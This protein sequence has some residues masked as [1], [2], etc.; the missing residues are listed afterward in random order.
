MPMERM[1]VPVPEAI[2]AIGLGR[3]K[4]YQLIRA[5]DLTLVHVGRRSFVPAESLHAFVER[6]SENAKQERQENSQ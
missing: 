4:F 6:L 5:G 2:Y 3:S 1:L